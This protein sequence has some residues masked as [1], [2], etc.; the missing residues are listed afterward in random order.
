[1][2]IVHYNMKFPD[3]TTAKDRPT[4]LSVLAFMFKN[5]IQKNEALTPIVDMLREIKRPYTSVPLDLPSLDS[6]FPPTYD[7]YFQYAEFAP[8]GHPSITWTIFKEPIKIE[9]TQL[10]EFRKLYSTEIDMNTGKAKL[11]GNNNRMIAK[12]PKLRVFVHVPRDGET[13][14]EDEGPPAS[15]SPKKKKRGFFSFLF[16]RKHK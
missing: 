4:G 16:R 8:S 14:T 3:I 13:S 11:L 1:M 9:E 6:I 7:S 2:H 5:S 12:I 10:A 15:A